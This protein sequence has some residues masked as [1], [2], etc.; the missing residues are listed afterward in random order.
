M[1]IPST[2]EEMT[3]LGWD[4]PDVILVTGD[5][6]IDAPN[7]GVSV[8]GH[9]LIKAGFRTVIIPQPGTDSPED[10]SRFG[11]PRLFWGITSGAVDSM[12]AN[13]TA[14]RK[15]RKNDDLTAG[16]VNNRR[17]DRA[18]IVYA[19]LIRRYFKDTVP[20]VLGGVEAS[21]R[22]T[23]HYDWWSDSI[24]RSI[25][26]DARG[27]I[28]VYGMGEKIVTELAESLNTGEE[29]RSIRGI[30][31][32]EKKPPADYIELPSLELSSSD[33]S[34]FNEM[35][36]LFYENSLTPSGKGF[37]QKHGDRWLVHNRPGA[38]LEPH[39]LDAAS[40]LPYERDVHPRHASEGEVRALDTIQ[41]SVTTHRGCA[42]E[43]SFCSIAVHQGKTVISRSEDSVIREIKEITRHPG[44]KGIISDMGG[45][46]ANMYMLSCRNMESRSPCVS[47]QCLYP[48]PCKN[49]IAGHKEQMKL[50]TRA[51]SVDK[52]KKV[53][54]ASGIRHDLIL[55]DKVNGYKYLKTLLDKHISGK[56]RV[57]PEHTEDRV[58]Q[59][60][61]K[62][63]FEEFKKF[64]KLIEKAAREIEKKAVLS[65]YFIAAHP[66]SELEDMRQLGRKS[67]KML[68]FV[69]ED[70]QI[71]TPLPSTCS[72]AMY[73]S[74]KSPCSGK[75]VYVEKNSRN[76]ENQ[77]KTVV[78][79]PSKKNY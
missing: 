64:I 22:R 1:F 12:V 27:D 28:L 11:E 44:F 52:V 68:G 78:R 21:L 77:K 57:A 39:E 46:T 50:L 41:F 53:F 26:F 49:L 24:R 70:V 25:L 10:I 30:C 37:K 38:P 35:F 31:Y 15:K 51:G 66:G 76:R 54:V 45:P 32:I 47:K 79:I 73:F 71:F 18:L 36:R 62:P 67:V 14:S 33:G 55:T 58:L 60:M 8:I 48:S 7:I 19:N 3:A 17:P 61:K 4:R 43:C 40:E 6:Y 75:N 56:M 16:L 2:I 29:W 34:K 20:V 59:L 63:S 65:C 72:A 69:P 42:G 74:G 23:A 13:Y 5:S 9:T